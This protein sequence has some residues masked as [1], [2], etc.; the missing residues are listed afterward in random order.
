MRLTPTLCWLAGAPRPS[1][2]NPRVFALLRQI[3]SRGS[4]RAA[5][6]AIAMPYRSAW[7]LLQEMEQIVGGPLVRLERGRGATLTPDGAK[8]LHADESARKRFAKELEALSVE[9]G[10]AATRGRDSAAPVLRIAAS[11]DPALVALQ[12]AIPVAAGV[13]LQIEFCGSLD[14][15]ARY[16]RGEVDLAG[17]HFVPGV[18]ARSRPFLGYLRPSH[19]RLVRFV[20][21]EQG[22]IVARALRPRVKNFADVVRRR[23]RFVNRQ[24]GS[25]TR[26]LI[27]TQLALEGVQAGDLRGYDNQEF[28]HAAVAATV[29]S[30]RADVGFGVA[31]AAAEYD[32]GFVPLAHEHYCFAVREAS[33]RSAPLVALRQALTGP[34]LK[35]MVSRMAGYDAT[36]SGEL[37]R[38]DHARRRRAALR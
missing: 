11:H 6:T 35:E 27:D 14:A 37:E 28:T 15:L 20:D 29:A 12:D 36:H 21:R 38:V 19:D 1:A 2:I 9:I 16:R 30:G 32:L 33:L 34:I 10:P 4:L 5:A 23:L 24:P 31:A 7:G 22:L 13:K 3:A 18:I 17:F 8:L 26:L 25:G